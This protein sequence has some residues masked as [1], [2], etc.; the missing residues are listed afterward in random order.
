MSLTAIYSISRAAS[1]F[2][3]NNFFHREI[4]FIL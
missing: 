4:Q 1:D 2:N 3:H